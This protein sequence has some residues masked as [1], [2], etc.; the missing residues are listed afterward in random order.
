[1]WWLTWRQGPRNVAH[2]VIVTQEPRVRA[3][4][5]DVALGSSRYCTPRHG[6]LC[7]SK[8]RGSATRWL[9]WRAVSPRPY[10]PAP[11]VIANAV[12]LALLPD[13]AIE[14]LLPRWRRLFPGASGAPTFG[15][16]CKGSDG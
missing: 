7:N 10:L 2:H 1:M 12:P 9:T 3:V 15:P 14:Q 16:P 11:H 13:L 6:T 8:S 4:L 5:D